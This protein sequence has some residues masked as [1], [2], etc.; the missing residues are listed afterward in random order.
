MLCLHVAFRW[1]R[2]SDRC[3]A[4]ATRATLTPEEDA[5]VQR[6]IAD[7]ENSEGGESSVW[8]NLA[9]YGFSPEEDARVKEIDELLKL[10]RDPAEWRDDAPTDAGSERD[11][12]EDDDDRDFIR[13]VRMDKCRQNDM[14]TPLTHLLTGW[15]RCD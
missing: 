3:V 9:Q 13:Q 15:C 11:D 14:R 2:P 5:W 1:A 12:G 4:A 8:A 6:L 10:Y 7:D